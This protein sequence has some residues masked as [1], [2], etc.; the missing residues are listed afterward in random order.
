MRQRI[1]VRTYSVFCCLL[2]VLP[3]SAFLGPH[4]QRV[5]CYALS[6]VSGVCA[7]SHGHAALIIDASEKSTDEKYTPAIEVVPL[8]FALLTVSE[9]ILA[10]VTLMFV[11]AEYS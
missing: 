9:F 3:V 8:C 11:S 7:C 5:R 1:G 2:L 4:S 10:D 6:R